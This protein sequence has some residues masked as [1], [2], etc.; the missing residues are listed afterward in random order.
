M[1]IENLHP[2]PGLRT[3]LRSRPG[4]LFSYCYEEGK[5][6]TL[7]FLPT[8][9]Y[10]FYYYSFLILCLFMGSRSFAQSNTYDSSAWIPNGRVND[11]VSNGNTVYLAGDFT[12]IGPAENVGRASTF[13]AV[14]GQPIPNFPK[15]DNSILAIAPDGSGGWYIGGGFRTVAGQTRNRLARINSDGSLHSWNPDVDGSVKTIAVSGNKVYVGGSFS[16][17]NGGTVTRKNVAAFDANT[18]LA[19]P[20]DPDAGD[21][22]WGD[23]RSITV[24][25]SLV[26]LGGYFN[27]INTARGNIL[28]NG[29]AA[30][31]TS[32]GVASS[33]NPR[34]G[35]G[36]SYLSTMT[37]DGSTLYVGGQFTSMGDSARK[38]LASFN[39][40]TLELTPWNPN[41]SGTIN[42]MLVSGSKVYLGGDFNTL[43]GSVPI[44]KIGSVDKTTGIVS[45]WNP[46]FDGAVRSMAMMG[47]TLYAGGAFKNV[48]N[49]SSNRLVALD[50]ITGNRTSCDLQVNN[51]DVSA[52][53]ASGGIICAGG[54]SFTSAGGKGRNRAAAINV[55]TGELTPWNP[56]INSQ[57]STMA[58]A[59][60]SIYLGG[61]F[62]K[63]NG[64][65]ARKGIVEVDTVTGMLTS[66]DPQANL[67]RISG[68]VV[69]GDTVY[70]GGSFSGLINGSVTRNNLAAFDAITGIVTS[71]DPNSSEDIRKLAAYKDTLYMY[72]NGSPGFLNGTTP[73][74]YLGAV[75]FNTGLATGFAPAPDGWGLSGLKVFG[76][77][78]YVGG[79]FNN[80]MGTARTSVAAIDLNTGNLSNWDP[81]PTYYGSANDISAIKAVGDV[82]YLGGT[83][84]EINGSV[85]RT[86]IAAVDTVLG[87]VLPW[88]PSGGSNIEVIEVIGNKIFVGGN[89]SNSN[90]RQKYLHV[91]SCTSPT[92]GGTISTDQ[93]GYGPF[94]PSGF[95]S[96]SGASGHSGALEYKWQASTTSSSAGFSDIAG[97]IYEA[98]QPD[99]LTQTTWFKR[100]ARTCG[101]T[102]TAAIESNVIE[103]TVT[104]C[105]NP[106][107]GGTI[108]SA[109][110]GLS[111]FDPAPF[112]NSTAA[113]GHSGT[114]EYKWQFSTTSDSTG[115]ADIASSDS[116]V[117]DAGS[118]TQTT[119]YKRVA[120]VGCKSDWTGAAA[121]NVL[122]V[123]VTIPKTWTGGNGNWNVA[124]N[125]SDGAV[126][127]NSDHL[128]INTGNPKLNVDYTVGGSLTLSGTGS[129][130]VEAGK[131]LLVDGVADFGSKS[132]T[133]IS[134]ATGTAQLGKVTGTL[135]GA[136]NVTVERFIPATG[137]KWRLLTAPLDNVSINAAWQNG[138]SWNGVSS[139]TGGTTGTLITGQ[140]QGNA[141]AANSRGFDFWSSVSN[142]STSLMTYT[143]QAGEGTWTQLANTTSANAF[144]NNKAYIIFIR[145]PRSSAYS[146]GT[147]FAATTLR[148]TGTLRHGTINVP[149]DGT[150]GYTLVGNPYASQIDFDSIY[151]NSGNSS[152][153]K[154]Q[155]WLWDA[156]GGSF[157]NY[158]AVV[159]SVDKYVEVPRKFHASGQ[160]TPLTAIQSGYGFFVLPLTSSGGVMQ[161]RESNKLLSQPVTPN[162][163]LSEDKTPRLFVNLMKSGAD[164][165]IIL[166]DGVMVS[167]GPRYRF[168]TTDAEDA[169]KLD[170]LYEN[171]AV[172]NGGVSLI[173]DARPL[174]E[175]QKEI[176]LKLWN[177][178]P[179]VYRFDSKFYG[180]DI[181]VDVNA[182]LEDK[183]SGMRQPLSMKGD[184][185]SVEFNISNDSASKAAD[186]F[187]IVFSRSAFN[188]SLTPESD[189]VGKQISVYPNPVTGRI[190]NIKLQQ[191]QAGKYQLQLLSSDGKIVADK[192]IEHDGG[193]GTYQLNLNGSLPQGNYILRCSV[194]DQSI[195]QEKLI[196]Q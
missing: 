169:I 72:F 171:M 166:A 116:N 14:T 190:V 12:Y 5:T 167:Y 75:D 180:T 117:Y 17:V 137:R 147:S 127:V 124:A 187:R 173:A 92:S 141:A 128:L 103:V 192:R 112:T 2:N 120:R 152:V 109:Q 26:F 135:N 97:A 94:Y 113:S 13:D 182:Y 96:V 181:G 82:I 93:S 66:W 50:T 106:T 165:K 142:S 161:I 61:N 163:L 51:E 71:W 83:I 79:D 131:T 185:S 69:R 47:G 194:G 91:Y 28:R 34:M 80:I 186:R 121:S 174:S 78:L 177:L 30:V 19:T 123:T 77:K 175:M 178:T 118:L 42:T 54:N 1:N 16:T 108:A 62:D 81:A 39:L 154:R 59:R 6:A 57:V 37:T 148:P 32:T 36:Y 88:A 44:K 35:T 102:W 100:L 99:T 146:S 46:I 170:N 184:L 130:T 25:D 95:T 132:V 191:V 85:S 159:Y 122:K 114:L 144:N 138:Q 196:I 33:W 183:F 65:I 179:G 151:R 68:I 11:M 125:W 143:Q 52:V 189:I 73:R 172:Q 129:L 84:S 158:H 63:A 90:E 23:I 133:F 195:S 29:F 168:E 119:W 160:A 193:A 43:N 139:L 153:I 38:N 40:S 101:N 156:A 157:G 126:P 7:P 134:D 58:L 67:T 149:V 145:G 105:T 136:D 140:Q 188:G 20:W 98:Y 76:D 3:S 162:I 74:N 70:V 176:N 48:N 10:H 21:P 111:P 64:N 115:F 110:S 164:G 22:S 31:D 107:S 56:N 41:T 45:A 60:G 53:A 49:I 86:K 15:F 55:S 4:T 104:Y 18:G 89:N 87:T 155:L 27:G 150:K 9:W 8:Q 24:V